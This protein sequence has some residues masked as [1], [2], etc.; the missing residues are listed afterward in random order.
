MNPPAPAQLTRCEC[1]FLP[2]D[3]GGLQLERQGPRDRTLGLPWVAIGEA[4]YTS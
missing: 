4:F 1:H 2:A 3:A